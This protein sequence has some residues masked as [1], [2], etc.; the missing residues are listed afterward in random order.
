MFS[1]VPQVQAQVD[2]T[3]FGNVVNP[4]ITNIVDPVIELMALVGIL[5]FIWGVVQMIM[6]GDDPEARVTGRNHMLWGIV[7]VVIM[8]S[9]W[10]IVFL[11]SNTIKGV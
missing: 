5:V 9:A 8:L 3:A 10:A 7:G 1:L 6:N 2:A 4:V 11:V